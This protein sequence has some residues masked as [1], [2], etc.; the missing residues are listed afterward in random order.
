MDIPEP[1]ASG[2]REKGIKS[3][4][5]PQAEALR[6]GLLDM[7]NMLVVAPTASGKTLIGEIALINAATKNGKGI[8]TTPLKALAYEKYSEFK[9]WE[10]YGIKVGIS[11]GDYIVTQEEIENLGR[12]DLIVTTY[13]RLDSIMRKRPR[14]FDKVRTVVIDEMHMLGD[15]SRGHI[16]E[17]I[18]MRAK[19]L[20]IQIVALSATIGNPE[21]V[22]KWLNAILIK[23]DWRP[24]KLYEVIAYKNRGEKTWTMIIPRGL[25]YGLDTITV[26]DLTNYWLQKAISEGFNVL[27]FKYS[28]KAVEELA[29]TYAP[30]LCKS[31]PDYELRELDVLAKELKDQ[32]HDFE[33]EKLYPLI[34]CGASY[35]HA[36]LSFNA[37]QFIEK[38][39][40]ERLLRYLAATPT[41]AM[42]VNLPA[43]VVIINTR[44]FSEKYMKRISIL[45][46]KQL[47]GRAGRPQYDPYGIVVIGKDV[48]SLSEAKRYIDGTP[49]AISSS[50]W[51]DDALRK[52]VLA[53]I[54]S[55]ETPTLRDLVKFFS[56]SFNAVNMDPVTI[57]EKLRETVTMLEELAMI[58][59]RKTGTEVTFTPTSLGMATSWLYIDPVSSFIIIDGLKDREDVPLLYY[60]SLIGMT[61]DFSDIHI[62]RQ[63]Y[64]WFEELVADLEMREEVP[65]KSLEDRAKDP[66]VDWFRGCL[67]GLILRDWIE[68]VPERVIVERYGIELG[69][70]GVIKETG[71]WLVFS[72]YIITKTVGLKRHS[73]K[74]EVLIERVRH[75]VREDVLDLVKLKYIGRVR[76]RILANN[77]IRNIKDII[78]KRELLIK[79]LGDGWGKKILEEVENVYTNDVSSKEE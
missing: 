79:L 78:E 16:V 6:N 51:N 44:Y 15:S 56:M 57:E 63:T 77:G 71:E 34:R 64:E 67:I 28:R 50:L 43:R 49:E 76:A 40:R 26:D 31:L 37:R 4:T 19:M 24:V 8:Y 69:D 14:W 72:A 21:E 32:L 62:A 7:N 58:R 30:V 27:E 47:S 38:A 23:S 33:Y 9:F 1:I 17:M 73:D 61:P 35:H 3:F 52:H 54:S 60:L 39:F 41:L 11:V 46:Y 25:P 22:A 45:E 20:G 48:P 36:G 55:G 53:S 68:E 66:N 12:F 5:P 18:A 13:E 75:G 2:L 74:L 70:L 59:S 10:R 42:G 65:S 29:Y